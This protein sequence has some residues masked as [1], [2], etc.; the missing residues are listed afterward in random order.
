M[1]AGMTDST[2]AS[3]A[4]D[5]RASGQP[6]PASSGR[7]AFL[8]APG[9]G[10][11]AWDDPASRGATQRLLAYLACVAHAHLI[12]ERAIDDNVA[13]AF[14]HA[15]RDP[16]VPTTAQLLLTLLDS[17]K[18]RAT[19]LLGIVPA[20]SSRG[21][22]LTEE[23]RDLLR[24]ARLE[25][26]GR[27]QAA[28]DCA[29][30]PLPSTL[31]LLARFVADHLEGEVIVGT[32]SGPVSLPAASRGAEPTSGPAVSLL[33]RDG[34]RL[35]LH[36]FVLADD[37]GAVSLLWDLEDG[38]L[39]HARADGSAAPRPH[40]DLP[41]DMLAEFLLRMGAFAELRDWLRGLPAAEREHVPR[42]TL[43]L[44]SAC[45][46]GA[47]GLRERDLDL[48]VEEFEKAVRA[49]PD[50]LLPHLLLAQ[51][52]MGRKQVDR[53]IEVLKKHAVHFNR[54]DRLF[55]Q[56]GDAMRQHKDSVTALRMYEKASDINPLN[57]AVARKRDLLRDQLRRERDERVQASQAAASPGGAPA[58]AGQTVKLEDFL[59]DMTLEAELGNYQGTVGREDEIRQIVEI[60]GCRDKRNPLLVGDPG[61]G[62]TAIVEDFVHR[63]V[64]G[65]LAARFRGKRVWLMSVGTL[66]AGAKY[67]GQFEERMLEIVR[68]LRAEESLVFV[69]NIHQLVSAGLTRGGALDA[70]ALLKPYLLK[71][72]LQ[73]IGAT[74]HDEYR[75]GLEKDG[76]LA[77][78]FQ[79]VQVEAP[80]VEQ[81]I[82]MVE[83]VRARYERH[84]G[85]AVPA[86][87]VRATLP[88]LDA[89]LREHALPDKAI[90]VYDRACAVAAMRRDGGEPREARA[91]A[92]PELTR[93][94]VLAVISEMSRVPVTRLAED[95]RQCYADLEARLGQRVVG[96]AD[97]VGRVARVLRAARLGMT[98]DPRRPKGVFFFVG[99][100]GVGK[101]ELARAM[102]EQLFGSADRL[103]RLDM[104]EYRERI[105]QSRL[106]GTAPGYVG[107]NDQNQLTDEVRR[108]PHSLVL[109]D[110]IEKADPEM[111]H[112][113]LQVFDAG[114]LTD[115]KGRT[116]HFDHATIVMTS[117][118]GTH[119]FSRAAV[120]FDDGREAGQG[121]RS[122]DLLREV[123]RQFSPEFLNRVDEIIC[124]RTLDPS[125]IERIT[126]LKV[127]LVARRLRAQGKSLALSRAAA[128]VI[129]RA[130]TSPA[131]GARNLERTIRRLLLEPLAARALEPGW[132]QAGHVRVDAR[133]S[134]LTFEL[135]PEAVPAEIGA[136]GL[137]AALE[138]EARHPER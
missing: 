61:V 12:G 114:R 62:K 20:E 70:S 118:V 82:G 120:G 63:L 104:S 29:V 138:P 48:A 77:R 98:V 64:S 65:Q 86:A 18:V 71:G 27:F 39:R 66:L 75:Q 14:Q 45:H 131:E 128:G 96:Q 126:H 112:L 81:A 69:D 107:Y 9:S 78:C 57:S 6:G 35:P 110:E 93:D 74:T 60:L 125:D 49:R 130:G 85:V 51:A 115:G 79:V 55:E 134:E 135:T 5:S 91:G 15:L 103:I 43:V 54:S 52:L 37:S 50:L 108:N 87:L 116:V 34:S 113:F 132:D 1:L 8:L 76:S 59:G 109:L 44:A 80:S 56:L 136:D 99:P 11:P 3:P 95:A 13:A 19:D 16:C 46:H 2:D 137:E 88:I 97:A 58:A 102:A 127:D 38:R 92:P 67:R 23:L 73:V 42:A 40:A 106:I 22:S 4:G 31:P 47:I 111:M 17:R 32:P 36:P 100:S 10:E 53:S 30:S 105:N 72:D 84:H 28:G 25:A 83:H 122:S 94:D 124:F 123:R 101:T 7:L 119:L 121:V 24:S 21:R 129:A 33:R 89:A 68:L 41:S 133:G 90:D 117:N 26:E